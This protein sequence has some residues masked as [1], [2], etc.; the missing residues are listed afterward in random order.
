[1]D[2]ATVYYDYVN[3]TYGVRRDD[4]IATTVNW[5][6]QFRPDHLPMC[7][8]L[9]EVVEVYDAGTSVDWNALSC[10]EWAIRCHAYTD[11]I[12][13]DYVLYYNDVGAKANQQSPLVDSPECGRAWN[14]P[15][16][17]P[18][19]GNSTHLLPGWNTLFAP[20]YFGQAAIPFYRNLPEDSAHFR[21]LV[22]HHFLIYSGDSI[23]IDPTYLPDCRRSYWFDD[24][25]GSDI[26]PFPE[27]PRIYNVVPD[28][29][30]W[31]SYTI[32]LDS[33]NL[34]SGSYDATVCEYDG[35]AIRTLTSFERSEDEVIQF[36]LTRAERAMQPHYVHLFNEA[37]SQKVI[38]IPRMINL[39]FCTE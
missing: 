12:P 6:G 31:R 13:D 21:Y 25:T 39:P 27:F 35:T 36:T 7:D 10:F 4:F 23:R 15:S 30:T 9:W 3:S 33:L 29:G 11:S 34:P 22:V 32:V 17:Y 37:D 2:V 14:F 18:I 24:S 20:Y 16:T 38:L 1:M 28:S 5:T 19:Y 26:D 8:T